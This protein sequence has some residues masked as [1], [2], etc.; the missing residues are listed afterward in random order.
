MINEYELYEKITQKIDQATDNKC[1]TL[2]KLGHKQ[3]IDREAIKKEC[4]EQY[5]ENMKKEALQVNELERSALQEIKVRYPEISAKLA[6]QALI[7]QSEAMTCRTVSDF[8]KI[9][10]F[11]LSDEE[12]ENLYNTGIHFFNERN[13]KKAFCYF[14]IFSLVE[15]RNAKAWLFKGLCQYNLG[16]Y[17][18]ALDAYTASFLIAPDDVLI[19]IEITTCLVVWGRTEEAKKIY[20]I[21]KAEANR[22]VFADD[23]YI[24]GRLKSLEEYFPNS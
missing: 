16:N 14:H 1:I 23:S 22:N 17:K 3:M 18:E 7:M 10:N 8:N 12:K 4:T 6:E 11:S 20:A 5:F 2:S 13:I 15:P 19:Q 21:L 24:E 9:S